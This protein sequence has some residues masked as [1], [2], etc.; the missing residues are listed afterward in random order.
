VVLIYYLYKYLSVEKF[1]VSPER[2]LTYTNRQIYE[3][4]TNSLHDELNSPRKFGNFALQMGNMGSSGFFDM[5]S[6]A[7]A[8]MEQ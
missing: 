3:Q 8:D 6:S 1:D 2:S 4:K 7:Q 5:E